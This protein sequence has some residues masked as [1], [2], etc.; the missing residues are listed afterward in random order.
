MRLNTIHFGYEQKSFFVF[1][2]LFVFF[3]IGSNL[4]ANIYLYETGLGYFD[5]L[6]LVY[7]FVI[8]ILNGNKSNFRVTDN[9]FVIFG[10]MIV[11]S[12]ISEALSLIFQLKSD[13]DLSFVRRVYFA[14]L[15]LLVYKLSVAS[16][17]QY[18][19]FTGALVG[20]VV[21]GI[22]YFIDDYWYAL[23]TGSLPSVGGIQLLNDQ[24]VVGQVMALSV[25]SLFILYILEKKKL[26]L[27]LFFL[28]FLPILMS[29]S[30]AAMLQWLVLLA[31]LFVMFIKHMCLKNLIYIILIGVGVYFVA[32]SFY[33]ESLN[34]YAGNMNQFFES[35]TV[36]TQSGSM[37]LRA[38]Y[39]FNALLAAMNSP[40]FGHGGK[41]FGYISNIL[42]GD[43]SGAQDSNAHNAF[44]ELAF[45][46]GY[47]VVIAFILIIYLAGLR[48]RFIVQYFTSRFDSILALTAFYCVIVL[49]ASVQNQIYSQP[50][51]YVYCGLVSGVSRKL[52]LE[53]FRSFKRGS[54]SQ[55][56]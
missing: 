31:L 21:G 45:S 43:W 1:A 37:D 29:Y 46:S 44:A 35:K 12:I 4:H 24:N 34:Q 53:S 39:L 48:S 50:W 36:Q 52:H 26:W 8:F 22:I 49:W 54:G 16:S 2:I 6:L 17:N 9:I 41:N 20:T 14:Y 33:E 28:A 25:L 18:L 32:V 7:G 27:I 56:G 38:S 55:I 19:A 40:I 47:V 15:F 30:K 10:I 13:I 51:F 5:L 42:P 3:T 23:A 11:I